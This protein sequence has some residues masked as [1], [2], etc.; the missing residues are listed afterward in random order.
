MVDAILLNADIIYKVILN[1][2]FVS[3]PEE[4]YLVMLTLIL[5]GEFD[6]WKED[7]CKKI[8][9]KWDYS[10][11]LIP[12]V[13]VA[14]L[15]NIFKYA[16]NDS[17]ISS[18]I[19]FFVFFILIAITNDILNDA[20]PFK[21][22]AKAFIF[23]VVGQIS[24]GLT[25]IIYVPFVLNA[26]GR[27]LT[28]INNNILLNFLISLPSRLIQYTFL[29][30][31]VNRKRKRDKGSF[32]TYLVSNQVLLLLLAVMVI[33]DLLF[34][35]VMYYVIIVKGALTG[36]PFIIEFLTIICVTMLP[37]LNISAMMWASFYVKN[38]EMNEKKNTLGM[39]N[40][41]LGSL[42]KYSKEESYENIP[43]KLNEIGIA[44]DEI[45]AGLNNENNTNNK[46]GKRL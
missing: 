10:R 2:L 16:G 45:A 21:W 44:I 5:I 19:C 28:E 3:I 43:W 13:I 39:L 31:L 12:S 33:F 32:F 7:E 35:I 42:D 1:T 40:E 29:A 41:V 9:N 38:Q 15:L 20:R 18:S 26:T 11:I 6:Y 34:L 46:G 14:L 23:L 22:L 36:T 30:I 4:I 37:L 24:I 25:E 27:T 17:I 8:I